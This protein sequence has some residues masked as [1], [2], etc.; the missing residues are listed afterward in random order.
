MTTRIR[1]WLTG[2]AVIAMLLVGG[3]QAAVP[4]TG[5]LAASGT[6]YT[7]QGC[8]NDQTTA[9][10]KAGT[11]LCNDSLY[12]TGDLGKGWAEL[13]LVPFRLTIQT[14]KTGGQVSRNLDVDY[15]FSNG[16]YGYDVLSVPVLN[17]SP[18]DGTD[19][20][21]RP[22][23]TSAAAC[24]FTVSPNTGVANTGSSPNGSAVNSLYR[25]L[26]VTNMPAN[27]TCVF[28]FYARVALG[29]HNITPGKC[30]AKLHADLADSSNNIQQSGAKEV[31]IQICKIN[32]QSLTKAMTATQNQDYSWDVVTTPT[33]A[34]ITFDDTCN[35][36]N[37]TSQ[38]NP[39]TVS[40]TKIPGD[41]SQIAI[42]THVTVVNPA[43]RALNVDVVDKVYAGTTLL[44]TLDSG[45]VAV[46][47][48]SQ[49]T[50][51]NDSF[52][53]PANTDTSNLNDLATANYTDTVTGR[54][55]SQTT[56]ATA[57]APLQTITTN[58]TAVITNT[59]SIVGGSSS[60][61]QFSVDGV[62]GATGN[63][64]G[65][66]TLGVKTTGPLTWTSDT[67]SDSGSVTF[68]KTVYLT[69]PA[70]VIATD[71]L[72]DSSNLTASS[73]FVASDASNIDLKSDAL[74][75]LTIN[76]S[77]SFTPSAS[78][79]PQTFT[80]DVTDS[81]TGNPVLVS[82]GNGNFVSPTVTVG[83]GQTSG[84]AIVG[85]LMNGDTYT[86]HEEQ[87]PGYDAPPVDQQVTV[88]IQAGNPATCGGYTVSFANTIH[89]D[90]TVQK[91][92]NPAGNE[93]GWTFNLLDPNGKQISQVTTTNA[94][95]IAFP[96]DLTQ[97]GQY[98]IQEVAQPGWA[99]SNAQNST[100]TVDFPASGGQTFAAQFTNTQ[101]SA[102]A[103]VQKVTYPGGNEAGW[104]F[105]L[106]D[107]N[108]NAIG[109]ATTT[110]T[111]AINFVDSNS[112][113]VKLTSAGTYT[114]KETSSKSGWWNTAATG[115]TFTINWGTG[116]TT[117]GQVYAAQFTNTKCVTPTVTAGNV[118]GVA[119]FTI[120]DANTPSTG[121]GL[122]GGSL[123]ALNP[124]ALGTQAS[125]TGTNGVGIKVVKL[126]NATMPAAS[127]SDGTGKLV[128]SASKVNS[129]TGAS[130]GLVATALGGT[131]GTV[132]VSSTGAVTVTNAGTCSNAFDPLI[133]SAI[134]QAG[135]PQ[136][137][138]YSG[139]DQSESQLTVYNGKPGATNLKIQVNNK[140]FTVSSLADGA[141]Q[142]LDIG[143]AL[144][145]GANNTVSVTS[146]G[147]PGGSAVLLVAPPG[148]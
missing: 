7:L 35:S 143:A 62:S 100:F 86:I 96:V 19:K 60:P 59:E 75:S 95:P 56:T 105:T 17:T 33:Y 78:D 140:V 114:V 9:P 10:Y 90:V 118:N 122:I 69:S 102:S 14:G 4:T 135:T 48:N 126:T 68:N 119:T 32:Q 12:T 41:P 1:P 141:Q 37:P 148:N 133:T 89:A 80:F 28:D 94:S 40:W 18:D 97:E 46:K 145:P 85:G 26:T 70:P 93:A 5:A 111:G 2:L 53:V 117:N 137:D 3:V 131:P 130:I 61:F 113:P 50:T 125:S 72:Q 81:T 127:W 66:Y 51:I 44:K 82:D 34:R 42:T 73:G 39:V 110:G 29:A 121:T 71:T 134:R 147:R 6:Q 129:S 36:T 138:N 67:Q 116:G 25:T 88:N 106:Y 115:Q 98:T 92:T 23:T 24:A 16:V 65:G 139:I 58:H 76:K 146:L 104:T 91:I 136:T 77:I 74:A 21:A 83:V 8:R 63:F 43:S 142:K 103:T 22:V 108:G 27:S 123:P 84:S 79:G 128:L 132:T 45:T 52:N 124:L 57:T 11:F 107:P 20:P 49:P 47:A 109:T 38:S 31:P 112:N 87:A 120:T 13:D 30:E 99:Q 144:N 55:I 15:L 54:P 101:E 64:G